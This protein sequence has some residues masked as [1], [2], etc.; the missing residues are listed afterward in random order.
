MRYSHS[1]RQPR[2]AKVTQRRGSGEG[3]IYRDGAYWAATIEVGTPGRRARRKVKARTKAEVLR[4]VKLLREQLDAGVTPDATM[5]VGRWLNH[6]L[7]TVIAERVGDKTAADYR[8]VIET[9]VIPALGTIV[10]AKLTPEQVDDFLAAN[11]HYSRSYVRRMRMLLADALNHALRRGLVGRNVADLAVM[12][13]CKEK[14]ERQPFTAAE[15]SNLIEAAK[16]ERLFALVLCG[17]LL[18][19]RPGELTGLIWN[20]L[21]LEATPPT[22]SITGSMKRRPDSSLYRG[23]VKKSTAGERTME[24]PP[25]VAV[26]L[27]EHRRRQA[28]ERLG[29]G[30]LWIDHGLIFPSE[31]GTPLDP[32]HLRRTFTRIAQRAGLEG[33]PYLMRHTVVSLLLDGG[34]TIDEV[35][36]LTG[37]DPATLYRHYRHKVQPVAAVAANL[38]P[39]IIGA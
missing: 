4:K 25:V 39:G 3:G 27:R 37:D 2:E 29:I 7:D 20:D 34:A 11:A 28:E 19:M 1:G 9:K 30:D 17:L 10:L 13:K 21:D 8:T 32:A 31:V 5:T 26:A 16:G 35:A 6:W 14:V 15:V 38:M 23:A 36:D 24:L 33:F 18:A 22:L 12:P